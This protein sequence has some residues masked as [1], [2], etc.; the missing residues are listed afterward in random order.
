MKADITDQSEEQKRKFF[1]GQ[2]NVLRNAEMLLKK[3]RRIN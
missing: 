2:E 1:P 3:K